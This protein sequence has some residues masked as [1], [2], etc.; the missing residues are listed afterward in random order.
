MEIVRVPMDAVDD[1]IASGELADAKS[2]IGVLTARA[3]LQ[4]TAGLRG[5]PEA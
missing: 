2:I 3:F 1:L 5:A 4:G